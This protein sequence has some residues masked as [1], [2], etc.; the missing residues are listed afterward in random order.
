VTAVENNALSYR[1]N[2]FAMLRACPK[3]SGASVYFCDGTCPVSSSSGMYT[4]A[5]VSH[6]APG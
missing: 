5:A 3:I 6:I 1:P 4:I 2:C